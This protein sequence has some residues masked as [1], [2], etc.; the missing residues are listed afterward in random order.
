MARIPKYLLTRSIT[1][2][3]VFTVEALA[4]ALLVHGA[5]FF[6]AGYQPGTRTAATRQSPGVTL[7]TQSGLP[8]EEWNKLVSWAAVHDPAQISRADARSGYV[9]LL[10]RH[11]ERAIARMSDEGAAG[12]LAAPKL[13]PLPG[14]TV[15][16]PISSAEPEPYRGGPF[17][18][19]SFRPVPP[20]REPRVTDGDGAQLRLARLRVPA[21]DAPVR[22]TI[23]TVWGVPGMMRQHLAESCGVSALDDAVLE[24]VAGERFETRKTIIV[25]WPEMKREE[26]AP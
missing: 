21:A 14:Y 1:P 9:A 20:V 13:P 3:W 25:Y 18:E 16:G 22:P 23:V 4:V 24:A 26:G 2:G 19:R 11:R 5:L 10:D 17:D 15:L 7:L 6:L 8:K 12:N